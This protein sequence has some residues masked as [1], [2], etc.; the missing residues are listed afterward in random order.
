MKFHK[1]NR[2]FT[3]IE[4]L[5]VVVIIGIMLAVI[6]PRAWRANVDSKYNLVRQVGSELASFA[7]EWAEKQ[8]EAQTDQ[9][10]ST[11]NSYLVALTGGQPYDYVYVAGNPTYWNNRTPAS[12]GDPIVGRNAIDDTA[13]ATVED[14]VPPEKTPRNPF[15]GASY[16]LAVNDPSSAGGGAGYQHEAG[17]IACAYGQDGS[18]NYFALLFQGTEATNASEFHAGQ[19]YQ[20]LEGLRNGIFVARVAAG[21]SGTQPTP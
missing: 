12:G 4:I 7:M 10:T 21:N 2:G 16:W 8:I 5:L 1:R 13:D 17:A 14:M 3:L 11:L 20:N 19:D 9:S 15:N 18:W 6:V